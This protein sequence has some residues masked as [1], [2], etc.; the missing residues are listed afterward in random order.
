MLPKNEETK[1]KV[2][3]LAKKK[4]NNGTPSSLK[5]ESQ[6]KNNEE[7]IDIA[8]E[9]T[10]AIKDIVEEKETPKKGETVTLLE[11][12]QLLIGDKPYGLVYNYRE[13]FDHEALGE[14]FSDV[15]ARYD[16]IVGD[17][18]YEQLRLKGFFDNDNKRA[19]PDQKI[20]TLQDYLYEYCNFGCAYFILKNCEVHDSFPA[21]ATRKKKRRKNSRSRTNPNRK[22]SDKNSSY[23]NRKSKI[24]TVKSKNRRQGSRHFVI[25][26]KKNNTNNKR[27][28]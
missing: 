13:G 2:S 14:R 22:R 24:Q 8:K 18:G 23:N 1:E 17:W 3:T 25:R 12:G 20:A 7:D 19:F 9:V 28:D 21:P 10:E 5:K 11:N 6:P 4:E 16:Y 27:R 15:L 26:K